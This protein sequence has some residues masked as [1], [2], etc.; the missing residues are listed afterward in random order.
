M[1]ILKRMDKPF[2]G[3][4]SRGRAMKRWISILGPDGAH[5]W[6]TTRLHY[7]FGYTLQD[8]L[9]KTREQIADLLKD[10]ETAELTGVFTRKN[11][12]KHRARGKCTQEHAISTLETMT[13]GVKA[14][15][16]VAVSHDF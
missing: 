2:S 11:G 5:A 13:L 7:G 14:V 12:T 9:D 15:T 3:V 6:E 8:L 4:V 10:T 1:D 16:Q